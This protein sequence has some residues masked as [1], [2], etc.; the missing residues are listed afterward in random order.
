[1]GL[2]FALV[3]VAWLAG[4]SGS[5][6]DAAKIRPPDGPSPPVV[7][8]TLVSHGCDPQSFQLK[9]GY[10]IFKV[11]N[12]STG[13]KGIGKHEDQ[14]GRPTEMEIQDAKG[15]AINDVEGVQP[16][17]TRSFVVKLEAGQK[18]RVRCPEE[19]VPWGTITVVP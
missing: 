9:A 11:T 12:P 4:C 7:P 6:D 18:Y 19:Q 1:V 13:D 2:L 14:E 10:V 5:S 3:A 17:R 16:G 15:H 8:V